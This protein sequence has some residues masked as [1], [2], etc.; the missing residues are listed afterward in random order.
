M[1]KAELKLQIDAHL[2]EQARAAQIDMALIAER[3]LKAALGPAAAEERSRAW[4]QDN[5]EAIADHNRRIRES[6]VFGEDL[7]S[8]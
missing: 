2:L 8:W 4:A 7:R 5:A 6:G 1:G 3:A